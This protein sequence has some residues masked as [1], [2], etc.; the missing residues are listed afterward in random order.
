MVAQLQPHVLKKKQEEPGLERR[1]G[2]TETRMVEKR[3][4]KEQKQGSQSILLNVLGLLA[5]DT[6][7]DIN[8]SHCLLTQ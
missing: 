2:E 1:R 4:R 3:R 8:T 6:V 7:W 5:G